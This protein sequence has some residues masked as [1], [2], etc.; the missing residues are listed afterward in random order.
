MLENIVS[1]RY[2]K[3]AKWDEIIDEYG[4]EDLIPLTVADMDYRIA[5]EIVNAVI[6]AANH[7]IYGYTNVSEKYIELSKMWAKNNYVFCPENEWIVYCPRIIQA[8]SLIIQ[9]YTEKNDKILVFTPLYD[10]I[11]NAVIIND[12]ELVECPLI[13]DSG[14]YEIDFE[15]FEE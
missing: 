3:C 2:T 12:R 5:P 10:P 7:G 9:N 1:R 13:L 11:Q 4:I 15:D 6:D 8:I 14:H